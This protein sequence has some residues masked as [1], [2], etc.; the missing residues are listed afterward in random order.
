[1]ENEELISYAKGARR[2]AYAKYSNFSVGAA[3]LTEKDYVYTGC[4]IENVSYG[5]TV[6]AERVAVFKAVSEG[7][8]KFKKIAIVSNNKPT[9][10]CGMCLQVLSEFVENPEEFMVVFE[11]TEGIV[12]KSLASLFPQAFKF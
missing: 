4:N 11:S 12:E 7:N 10:P 1:M 5:A 3:L 2:M 9:Y 8:L 6:C